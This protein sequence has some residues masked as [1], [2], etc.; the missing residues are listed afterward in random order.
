MTRFIPALAILLMA[1]P[2]MAQIGNAQSPPSPNS[3]SS[4]P[5]TS[6]SVP[7]GSLTDKPGPST[8]ITTDTR[9]GA[10]IPGGQA[11]GTPSLPS[12]STGPTGNPS[13]GFARTVPTPAK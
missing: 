11:P 7:A 1:A 3:S 9:T 6:G 4:A 2:A 8:G 13:D 5:Q 12:G 10:V